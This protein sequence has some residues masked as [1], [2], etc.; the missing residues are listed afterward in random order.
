MLKKRCE[1]TYFRRVSKLALL[2]CFLFISVIRVDINLQGGLYS[3]PYQWQMRKTSFYDTIQQQLFMGSIISN[4]KN[5]LAVSTANGSSLY[6]YTPTGLPEG[7]NVDIDGYEDRSI[8]DMALVYKGSTPEPWLMQLIANNSGTAPASKLYAVNIDA[9]TPT[10]FSYTSFLNNAGTASIPFK[11]CRAERAHADVAAADKNVFVVAIAGS[12]SDTAFN[13]T[14]SGACFRLFTI[15][16]GGTGVSEFA[17]SKLDASALGSFSELRDM[18]WDSTLKR[19]YCA[20]ARTDA[21][22]TKTGFCALYL[23]ETTAASP[24]LKFVNDGELLSAPASSAKSLLP[25]VHKVRTITTN[26]SDAA[27]VQNKYLLACGG[28]DIN[29]YNRIYALPLLNLN[30][31]ASTSQ[32]K[33][34]VKT[35]ASRSGSGVTAHDNSWLDQRND[36]T[37]LTAGLTTFDS[38]AVSTIAQRTVGCGPVPVSAQTPITDVYVNRL[39]VYVSVADDSG[40]PCLYMTRA[41]VAYDDGSD[42]AVELAGHDGKLLGW[43]PWKK[44][45]DASFNKPIVT[46][47][48]NTEGT[49]LTLFD[50]NTITDKTSA[51]FPSF[52]EIPQMSFS[53]VSSAKFDIEDMTTMWRLRDIVVFNPEIKVLYAGTNN[54]NMTTS[55]LRWYQL[56]DSGSAVTTASF[57][58]TVLLNNATWTMATFGSLVLTVPHTQIAESIS[59]GGNKLYL[60]S[61]STVFTEN[62]AAD[63]KDSS[64]AASRI[65][66]VISAEKL[67]ARVMLTAIP[68]ATR[69]D[70]A[71]GN[72]NCIRMFSYTM[73]SDRVANPIAPVSG[74]TFMYSL[75]TGAAALAKNSS[76]SG[77]AL[78]YRSLE[79]MYFD[80]INKRTYLAFT[81]ATDGKNDDSDDDTGLIFIGWNA[82]GT[83]K[84]V[85]GKLLEGSVDGA[86]GFKHILKLA[87]MHTRVDSSDATLNRSYLI[88]NGTNHAGV[89]TDG[90]G[91]GAAVLNKIYALPLVVSG[92]NIGKIAT[93]TTHATAANLASETWSETASSG[94]N[95]QSHVVGGGYLPTHPRSVITGLIVSGKTVFASVANPQG[96][97]G[98]RGIF[99][100]Q[101][102]TDNDEKLVAWTAWK[103]IGGLN[104]NVATIGYSASTDSVIA[105][106]HDSSSVQVISWKNHSEVDAVNAS[107]QNLYS[108]AKKVEADFSGDNS[109]MYSLNNL[110]ISSNDGTT[111]THMFGAFGYDKLALGYLAKTVH[112]TDVGSFKYPH[113][114]ETNRYLLYPND[115]ELK[116]IKSLYCMAVPPRLPGWVFAGG[117]RGLA[118]L[119]NA[120]NGRGFTA[121]PTSFVDTNSGGYTAM[122]AQTWLTLPGVVGPVYKI[123]ATTSVVSGGDTIAPVII[124]M[125]KKGLTAFLATEGKFKTSSPDALAPF[126]TSEIFT[127]PGEYMRD[128]AIVGGR[129]ILVGTSKGLYLLELSSTNDSFE[130]PARKILYQNFMMGPI[131]AIKV[132][133]PKSSATTASDPTGLKNSWF[134]IDV[135]TA[136][137]VANQSEHY[138]FK[139]KLS[140]SVLATSG[141]TDVVLKRSF[142]NIQGKIAK[143]GDATYYILPG[144]HLSTPGSVRV[145]GNELLSDSGTSPATVINDDA[146]MSD[147]SEVPTDG[148]RLMTIDGLVSAYRA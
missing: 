42:S 39:N 5:N 146:Q 21:N 117:Y 108:F 106:N 133:A 127:D 77:S 126:D 41:L 105:V 23:D 115:S 118:V 78:A 110:N 87:T 103:K 142:T 81:K 136:R 72:N 98:Q 14:S 63:I 100:S 122:N 84:S 38:V 61:G 102:I 137:V 46:F 19:L 145:V 116:Q 13:S 82:D 27:S 129:M 44:V 52:V 47:G 57:A 50:N 121:L 29:S 59:S 11:I 143:F 125:T 32:G 138:Q 83:A 120:S 35:N 43:T 18:W 26:P 101:A 54:I 48:I 85:S 132:T 95:Y 28:R 99:F 53:S 7:S 112:A 86:T 67:T 12:S 6:S 123:L 66:K 30:N 92:D 114:L 25:Y 24:V 64:D 45:S 33:I 74:T 58:P 144:K 69:N 140:D 56:D 111:T 4:S 75:A 2:V 113:D 31:A 109:K 60:M 80:S 135:L 141:L 134:L 36:I 94:A 139:I 93:S 96:I 147:I 131:G 90:T 73:A 40:L 17:S 10:Y 71:S 49:L 148:A 9:E 119:R 88:F 79:D 107:R 22:E 104:D 62:D 8:W 91:L 55:A 65:I 34:D 3:L 1:M 70:F 15:N 16:S 68:D 89:A 37:A 128:M 51:Q 97:Q 20:F 130:R 124:C 76:Q